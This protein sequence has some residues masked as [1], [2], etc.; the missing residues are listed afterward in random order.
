MLHVAMQ[1]LAHIVILL[2]AAQC[3]EEPLSL[4]D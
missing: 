3:E 4:P 2:W 1:L